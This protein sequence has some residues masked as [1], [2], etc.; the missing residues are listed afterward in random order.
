MDWK[1]SHK[2]AFVYEG[3]ATSKDEKGALREA[4]DWMR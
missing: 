3:R 4:P 2:L 1:R